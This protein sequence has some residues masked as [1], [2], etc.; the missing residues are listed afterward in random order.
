LAVAWEDFEVREEQ[1]MMAQEVTRAIRDS[2]LSIIEAGTGTGKTLAYL[3]PALLSGKVTV[4]STGLKNLQDQIFHKD[5]VFLKKYF[6]DHFRVAL[7]KGRENYV[8]RRQLR[9]VVGKPSLLRRQ[10]DWMR[11]LAHWAEDTL[12]GAVDD[13]PLELAAQIPGQV[14][15]TSGSDAC[16]GQNCFY[17]RRCFFY[18]NKRRAQKA[19]LI[20]VNHHVFM[21]DLAIKDGSDEGGLLP[22]WQTLVF[23]E[24]HMLEDVATSCFGQNLVLG[25]LS[26]TIDQILDLMPHGQGGEWAETEK[27]QEHCFD[28]KERLEQLPALFDQSFDQPHGDEELYPEGGDPKRQ[29]ETRKILSDIS[30]IAEDLLRALPPPDPAG[31]EQSKEV[32]E[33]GF[34]DI[35]DEERLDLFMAKLSS[36]SIVA[37]LLARG[38]DEN[39]VYQVSS[40][41][42]PGGGKKGRNW[43]DAWEMTFSALPLEAG[44]ILGQKL[45]EAKRTVILTSATLS[46]GGNFDY[47]RDRF[48][49]P[50]ETHSLALRSPFDYRD[51]TRLYVPDH[52][53]DVKSRHYPEAFLGEA[54]RLIRLSKGRTLILFTS[55]KRMSQVAASL[56]PLI[57][58]NMLV[59]SQKPKMQLLREF[60]ADVGSVLLATSSFWQGVDVP[61]ESLSVVIVDNLPFAPPSRPIVKGR[62]R[63]LAR[64]GQN[65]F[66]CYSLPEMILTLRQGLG[67]L[68][69]TSRDKGLLA[70][71]DNRLIRQKYGRDTIK[72]LPPSPLV[73][74]LADIAEFLED[75]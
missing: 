4:V 65:S 75:L 38:S 64:R 50:P 54:A 39:Y 62:C 68:L 42:V 40:R 51:R 43:R 36:A 49:F 14:K 22:E 19:N 56:Q 45:M 28:L 70:V 21:A 74:E 72:F 20:L 63:L 10:E 59:Q 5:L 67:R 18:L 7:L 31:E 23:D 12:T 1:I 41:K 27:V 34:Y 15:L 17:N 24:A 71:F 32:E 8:C 9:R 29:E 6:G 55:Y 61:G 53:P 48:G 33:D 47:L 13:I 30:K 52:L 69:R 37:D 26:Q 16:R 3:L 46:T 73:T 35:P 58:F 11:S 60:K 57:P 25:Q 66:L 44:L 2:D